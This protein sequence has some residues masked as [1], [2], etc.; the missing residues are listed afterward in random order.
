MFKINIIKKKRPR[1]K[2]HNKVFI[3]GEK[4]PIIFRTEWS[5]KHKGYRAYNIVGDDYCPTGTYDDIIYPTKEINLSLKLEDGWKFYT[6]P[7][8]NQNV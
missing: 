4:S 8:P 3:I 1:Y 7:I 5:Q 6:E 2:Y